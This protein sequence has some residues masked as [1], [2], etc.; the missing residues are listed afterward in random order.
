MSLITKSISV[1]GT[2]QQF[3]QEL[4]D[5]LTSDSRIVCDTDLDEQYT[6]TASYTATIDFTIN[7]TYTLRLKRNSTNTSTTAAY[8]VSV[9]INENSYTVTS[10]LSFGSSTVNTSTVTTRCFN[11]AM[12]TGDDIVEIW[13]AP[14]SAEA[15]SGFAADIA[16]F[17]GGDMNLISYSSSAATPAMKSDLYDEGGVVYNMYDRFEFTLDNSHVEICK[18]K[19]ILSGSTSVLQYD[20]L[21]DC[22]SI[23][24]YSTVTIDSQNYYALS[25]NTL[26]QLKTEE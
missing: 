16:L 9:I 4:V 14:Y 2:E 13:L 15:P 8:T 26:I 24:P 17:T 6:N 12:L 20:G 25:S 22:S 18:N 19:R 5:A 11:L 7:S 21:I 1:S 23:S 10:N 3:M